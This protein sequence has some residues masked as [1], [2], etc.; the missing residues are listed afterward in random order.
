MR[1]IWLFLA[2]AVAG[3]VVAFAAR[4]RHTTETLHI[5]VHEGTTLAFDLSPDGSTIAFDLLGQLW[6]VPAGGGDA[7]PVTD[8]VRDTAEDLDPSWSPDGKQLVFRAERRGRTGLWLVQPGGTPRQLSQLS[9]PDGFEGGAA[10]SPDGRTLAFVRNL[11]PDSTLPAWRNQ[12]ATINP[13]SGDVHPL[14]VP[15]SIGRGLSDPAWAPDGRRLAFIAARANSNRPGRIWLL[16]PATGRVSPLG[17]AAPA[18][19]PAF[20]PAG[21]RLAFFAQDS[22][23][24]MQVWVTALA[25]QSTPMR[26]TSQ[27]DVTPTRVRWTADGRQLLYGADGRLWK[28]PAAGGAPSEIPF[29]ADLRLERPRRALP[30]VRFPAPG[31]TQ[32][33]R[34]FMGLALSP[35]AG[36]IAMLALGRLWVMPVRGT[37]RAIADVPLTAHRLAWSPDGAALVWSAGRWGAT[38]LFTT[39]V[40]TGQT[41][42]I[43]SLP[44]S[45]DFPAFAPDGRHL[46]FLY[47]PEERRAFLR[48]VDPEARD[49]RDSSVGRVIPVD[50]GADLAWSPASDRILSLTGGFS[51]GSPS[52]GAMIPLSG[53]PHAVSRVPDSPLFPLWTARGLVFV[54]HARLWRAPFDSTGMLAEAQSLGDKPVIYPSASRDGTILFLSTGGLHLLHPDGR[55]QR[56]GWPLSYTPP[57]ARPVLI[58][59]V[60]LI[61]GTGRPPTAARDVLIESGRI[62]RIAAPGSLQATDAEVMDARGGFAMPGLMDLHAHIYRPEQLPDYAYFG[63]SVVRDQGSPVGP[64]VAWADAIAAGRVPGPRVDYGGIQFYTDWAYDAEDGQGIEPEADAGHATRAVA[65][66]GAIGSQHIKTRTFRRWD[67]NA[68]LIAEAHRLGMRATGHC[69]HPLPLIAAGM[70]AKEHGGFCA[71]R[72]DGP[73][74]QDMLQLFRAAGVAVIPTIS[75]STFAVRMNETPHWLEADT[76]LAPFVPEQNSFRWMMQLDSA[77]RREFERF[78]TVSQ[79]QAAAFARAGVTIGT[80]TDIWQIPT[81]VHMELEELVR[82]GLTPLEAIH[83]A[84]GAAAKII[85]AE[86][87]LGTLEE[88]KLADLV[89]L[90]AD[91]AADIRNTRRIR[92]VMLSG[93]WVDREPIRR[94]AGASR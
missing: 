10:W 78:A 3:L 52:R 33:V 45:E 93:A 91:P 7:R 29:T 49:I 47:Q 89:L 27:A 35:D 41:Q 79:Q 36:S 84:T 18:L 22:L 69:A 55:D 80:G 28:I 59:N 38:D 62:R 53:E 8:A 60:H 37:A 70:D 71:A 85:G 56:I 2:L 54:R 32:P 83:A 46:S 1:H 64:L 76:E 19:A 5:T 57:T 14:A 63:V 26:L 9:N 17:L 73:L 74:Y 90:D 82:A 88:G 81:A 13:V 72:T 65:L 87:E 16:E 43:T 6:T 15:D 77:G 51:P 86:R 25:A 21:D 34:S 75:Y 11:P 39:S 94:Q 66:A 24:R 44:G 30:P 31:R 20:A 4:S 42:R 92:A 58:R 40:A 12:L 61:D 23:G 48:I 67:I 50:A 68:R